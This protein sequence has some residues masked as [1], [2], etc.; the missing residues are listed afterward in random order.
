VVAGS[1]NINAIRPYP[2]FGSILMSEN[3]ANS[4]YNALQ[5]ELRL[6]EVKGLTLQVAY[7]YSKAY[8]T[9]AGSANGGNGGD[10]DTI[11]DPYNRAYDYG[12]STYNRTNIFLVDYMY[13]LP[14]FN[15]SS[16]PFAKTLLGGWQLSGI[17]TAESGLPFNV[18]MAANTLGMSNYNNRPNEVSPVTY[19]GTVSEFFSTAS[20]A[21]DTAVCA[22]TI[23][24]FGNAPKNAVVGPGRN[25]FD[26][27]LFKDFSGIKWWNPEGATLEFR[28]ETFNTFNHTQFQ[29]INT[30]YGSSAFGNIT[31]AYDPRVNQ[32]GLKFL[33]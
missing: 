26:T 30:T 32:L 21:Y 13:K 5:T 2:G 23:C 11:S 25:N 22:T 29:S 6:R 9:T 20:F 17:V 31:S 18:T 24:S 1:L 12:L 10:Q 14:F 15:H 16:N 27:S 8:D 3:A 7:T 4:K 19:P 28:A 33:F